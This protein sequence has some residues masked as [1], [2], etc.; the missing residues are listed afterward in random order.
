VDEKTKYVRLGL[1]LVLGAIA[2][3]ASPRPTKAYICSVE[4]ETFQTGSDYCINEYLV[5]VTTKCS[6]G[7]QDTECEC[8]GLVMNQGPAKENL[9]PALAWRREEVP[10]AQLV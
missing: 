9:A 7:S 8:S 3:A 4:F 5:C 6:N 10:V 1:I 2:F